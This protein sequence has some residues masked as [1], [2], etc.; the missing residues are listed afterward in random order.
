MGKCCGGTGNKN[1]GLPNKDAVLQD[2]VGFV[3]QPLKADDGTENFIDLSIT[4]IPKTTVDGWFQNPDK[5]KRMYMVADIDKTKDVAPTKEAPTTQ[6]FSDGTTENLRDGVQTWVSFIKGMSTQYLGK[7]E[8]FSCG[9]FGIYFID[10][11]GNYAGYNKGDKSKTYPIKLDM[12]TY[13]PTYVFATAGTTVSGVSF[14][15]AFARSVQDKDIVYIAASDFEEPIS[16]AESLLDVNLA[17]PVA[18]DTTHLKFDAE[19][20]YGSGG[21]PILASGLDETD[22]IVTDSL[23]ASLAIT[24]VDELDGVG[25]Y[26]IEHADSSTNVPV[27]VTGTGLEL[28]KG[29]EIE[30]TATVA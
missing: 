17:N 9:K 27:S 10:S 5:S 12:G 15:F 29:Y 11:C 24:G 2:V 22:F 19:T 23:G 4:P 8:S 6:S 30:N 20:C 14:A 18:P 28:T 26:T 16:E 3:L 7:L 13:L 21:N 25:K 1:T